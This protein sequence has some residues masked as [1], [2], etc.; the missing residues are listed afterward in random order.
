M[1]SF[2]LDFP[3][4]W[5]REFPWRL[6][7]FGSNEESLVG[8]RASNYS[9]SYLGMLWNCGSIPTPELSWRR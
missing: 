1:S 4:L 7:G 9:P 5:L 2:E 8:M 6:A 3:G